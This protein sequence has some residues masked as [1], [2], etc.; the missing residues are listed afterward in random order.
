MQEVIYKND[1][2]S[3]LA[4]LGGCDASDPESKG[5]D[6]AIDAAKVSLAHLRTMNHEEIHPFEKICQNILSEKTVEIQKQIARLQGMLDGY[7]LA[8]E[9]FLHELK[10]GTVG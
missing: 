1:V 2:E 6:S 5:W 8:C 10:K 9:D 7:D 4:D 3:M